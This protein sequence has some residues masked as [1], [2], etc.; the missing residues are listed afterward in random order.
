MLSVTNSVDTFWRMYL[1]THVSL[2]NKT[3]LVERKK[4]RCDY[5]LTK[6]EISRPIFTSSVSFRVTK[7]NLFI[8]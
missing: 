3:M 4:T 5:I 7:N 6:F 8:E 2:N 1:S